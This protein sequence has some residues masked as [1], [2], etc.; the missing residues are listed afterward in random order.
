MYSYGR[1]V[2]VLSLNIRKGSSSSDIY[3]FRSGRF[4]RST[5]GAG[6]W[7]TRLWTLDSCEREY[8]S[9]LPADGAGGG[10]TMT[11]ARQRRKAAAHQRTIAHHICSAS[12]PRWPSGT[13]PHGRKCMLLL[14]ASL[15]SF[16]LVEGQWKEMR[17]GGG[18]ER[19]KR[20]G[21]VCIYSF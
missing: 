7:P 18:G 8:E 20:G 9:F 15:F 12:S 11:S 16:S 3:P 1:W 4:C 2:I 21:I 13:P 17:G 5:A 6:V 19:K 14:W 10:H